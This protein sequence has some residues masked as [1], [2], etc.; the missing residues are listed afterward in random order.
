MLEKI[1]KYC[2]PV[3]INWN[4]QRYEQEFNS[5]LTERLLKEE[6]KEYL[7]ANNNTDRLDAIGDYVFV[8]LGAE[9]KNGNKPIHP[10]FG[11]KFVVEKFLHEL[12]EDAIIACVLAV[13]LSNDTKS[14]ERV[15]SAVKANKDKGLNYIGPE[16]LLG[17]IFHHLNNGWCDNSLEEVLLK[18]I[19]YEQ[20]E[21]FTMKHIR[22]VL[23]Y[24]KK[25][26]KVD[27]TLIPQKQ[28]EGIA[29]IFMYGCEKYTKD[30]W[31]RAEPELYIKAA[32]R[33]LSRIADGE[34]L[35][36]ESGLPHAH[37]VSTNMIMYNYLIEENNN[38]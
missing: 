31:K 6:F 20:Y 11:Y 14:I 4:K 12:N 36:P 23:T 1:R 13:A 29:K 37:H 17:H 18:F 35:D 32:Y 9:W 15:A 19:G 24:K 5:I 30:D 21:G 8:L 33:H 16:P 2:S 27:F 38:E 28:L 26:Q 25:D 22:K 7:D 3:V 10:S 34:V